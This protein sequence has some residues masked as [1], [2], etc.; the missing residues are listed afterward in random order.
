MQLTL[1]EKEARTLRDFLRDHLH[2]LKF[3]VARTDVKDMRHRFLEQ[4]E[5]VERL[6]DD[7]EREVKD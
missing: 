3:E 7:L 6:L 1:T 5:V 4:Q 2:T